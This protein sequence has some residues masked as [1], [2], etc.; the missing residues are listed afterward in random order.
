MEHASEADAALE[1]F[2]AAVADFKG[3][4]RLVTKREAEL[5]KFQQK[6]D[7]YKAEYVFL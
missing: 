2:K 1:W 4:R 6:T 3:E 5:A 7:A